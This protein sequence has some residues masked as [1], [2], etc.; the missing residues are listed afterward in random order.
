MKS[1]IFAAALLMSGAALAQTTDMTTTTSTDTG[2]TA[3]TTVAPGNSAPERDARGI[4]VV[5]DAATA[6]PGWNMPPGTP[7]AANPSAP[8][9]SQGSA[10]PLPPCTRKITDRCTQ[11]YERGRKPSA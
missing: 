11:T 4:A 1:M 9:P 7:G 3:G 6:P 2:M 8:P 10:G 5:S